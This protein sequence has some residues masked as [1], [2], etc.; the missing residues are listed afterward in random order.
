MPEIFWR[1][2]IS[3]MESSQN[4][5][6]EAAYQNYSSL[7]S[8]W[9]ESSQVGKPGQPYLIK[10]TS[11]DHDDLVAAEQALSGCMDQLSRDQLLSLYTDD[12]LGLQAR[13][14]LKER[15]LN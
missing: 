14:I 1:G 15:R 7:K 11:R 9:L 5:G 4:S 3:P 2:K 8:R 10:W 6:C 12:K 13:A